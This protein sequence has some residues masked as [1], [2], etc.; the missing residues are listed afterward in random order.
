MRRR[1][2]QD[3]DK[4]LLRLGAPPQRVEKNRAL[5]PGVDAGAPGSEESVEIAKLLL[6]RHARRPSA[7]V[8]H[9]V[10]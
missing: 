4:G 5:D 9:G 8:G 6:L 3:I 10:P 2:E 1:L 7:G